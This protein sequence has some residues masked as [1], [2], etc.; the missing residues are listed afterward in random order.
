M[1]NKY[2]GIS[3]NAEITWN[4]RAR[5]VSDI[6]DPVLFNVFFDP[7][8]PDYAKSMILSIN[9]TN[10]QG[11]D[12]GDVIPCDHLNSSAIYAIER[13]IQEGN[14][15]GTVTASEIIPD[16]VRQTMEY[17]EEIEFDDMGKV[18]GLAHKLENLSISWEWPVEITINGEAASIDDLGP[19]AINKIMEDML[20][21]ECI[22]GAW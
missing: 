10:L 16:F 13:Q 6:S 12:L 17:L 15:S 2:D 9:K 4:G 7:H 8:L 19:K 14:T 5:V 21:K 20:V 18:N 3:D 11:K 1:N 22:C